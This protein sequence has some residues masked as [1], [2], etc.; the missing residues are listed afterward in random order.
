[1]G[2]L[3]IS[4]A[5]FDAQNVDVRTSMFAF[6]ANEDQVCLLLCVNVYYVRVCVCVRVCIPVA[7]F[8]FIFHHLIQP[9]TYT[10]AR[11]EWLNGCVKENNTN[12]NFEQ[13][14]KINK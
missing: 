11:V 1:M 8:Y 2:F 10:H 14:N 9:H 3:F 13:P 4:F 7:T 5:H 6:H 12:Q